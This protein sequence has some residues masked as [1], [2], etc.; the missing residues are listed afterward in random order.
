M[1]QLGREVFHQERVLEIDCSNF[2]ISCE[3]A[4]QKIREQPFSLVHILN[5]QDATFAMRKLL[6]NLFENGIL[7]LYHYETNCSHVFFFIDI[8]TEGKRNLSYESAE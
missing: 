2:D 6:L 8:P 1:Q 3:F 4:L 5:I 7:N